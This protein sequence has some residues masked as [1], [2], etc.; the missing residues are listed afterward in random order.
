MSTPRIDAHQHFWRYQPTVHDGMDGAMGAIKRDF[1]PQDL[2]LR[3]AAL[4]FD[5]CVAVQASQTLEETRWLLELADAHAFIQGMVGWVDLCLPD[6]ASQLDVFATHPR[7]KGIRH[8]VQ[9]A[10]Y[11]RRPPL[12]S[13]L[14]TAL[15]PPDGHHP[16][17]R[18]C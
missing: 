9:S 8:V 11:V 6:V 2:T 10:I 16:A 3:L 5:G 4:G 14:H 18:C 17:F 7:L 12:S 13:L 1:L 15:Y